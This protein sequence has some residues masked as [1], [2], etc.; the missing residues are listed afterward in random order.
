MYSGDECILRR[1]IWNNGKSRAFVN[2]AP[3]LLNHLKELADKL[4]DIHSQH[5]NLSLSDNAFQ[6]RVIDILSETSLE[7]NEYEK[8]YY[9]YKSSE[10]EFKRLQSESIK[11]R[12][13]EDFIRFQYDA[14]ND[15]QLQ[16]DEQ[17]QLE[18]ELEALTHSEDIKSGLFLTT[19]LLSDG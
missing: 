4:I 7:L 10:K 8:A 6:L 9:L 19:T 13:E 15:A 5:Q 17:E 12:E 1:E 14:L 3:V 11:S 2:D 16:P 18:A